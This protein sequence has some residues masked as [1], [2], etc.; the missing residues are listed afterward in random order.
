MVF[1]RH[2]RVAAVVLAAM[3][4]QAQ[5]SDR[6]A[7]PKPVV[8]ERP[9][10]YKPPAMPAPAFPTKPAQ[11]KKFVIE[12]LWN[13][14]EYEYNPPVIV[15]Q[16]DRAVAAYDTPEQAFTSLMSAMMAYD[17]NWWLSSFTDMSQKKRKEI[18]KQQNLTQQTWVSAWRQMM[19][20]KRV[21]LEKRV[22]S[23]DF[24]MLLYTLRTPDDKVVFRSAIPFRKENTK[25]LDTLDLSED[26]FFHHYAEGEEKITRVVR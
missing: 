22:D 20:G 26:E 25:W 4:A 6:P 24:V 3:C 15:K 16:V 21:Q 13:Y 12:Y 17:Y 23:G 10:D 7:L 14:K 8:P 2:F 5:Q 18:D 11:E 1:L 19:P 9:K